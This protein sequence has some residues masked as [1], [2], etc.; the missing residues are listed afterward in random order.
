MG[1][2]DKEK[3]ISFLDALTDAL[4]ESEGVSKEDIITDM[5]E[6]GIDVDAAVQRIQ[7]IVEHASRKAKRQQLEIARERRLALEAEK[8]A[9][10]AEFLGW[11]KEQI[12]EKINAFI[13][14]RGPL[15]TVSYRE[16]ESKS[17]EDLAALLEDMITTKEMEE[18]E[19]QNET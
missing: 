19:N 14:S 5:K 15:A 1:T 6:E 8:P 11:T 13:A 10:L 3:V 16:L 12:I 2:E 17:Q 18:K 7:A 4:G 9:R